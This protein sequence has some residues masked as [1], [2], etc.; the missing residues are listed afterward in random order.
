M[1]LPSRR[2]VEKRESISCALIPLL[3]ESRAV[4]ELPIEPILMNVRDF[5]LVHSIIGQ[6]NHIELARWPLRG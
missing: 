2:G 6:H 4:R 5:V 3:Y 1:A